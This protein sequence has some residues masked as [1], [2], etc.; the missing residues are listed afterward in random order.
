MSSNKS[1]LVSEDGEVDENIFNLKDNQPM[2]KKAVVSR[3][4]PK[5]IC[6]NKESKNKQRETYRKRSI[7]SLRKQKLAT[8]KWEKK[9]SNTYSIKSLWQCNGD[10]G[11]NFQS[12]TLS[13]LGK[14]L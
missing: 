4:K 12:Y 10:L 14:S 5:K 2:I 13:R 11:F 6:W 3:G 7:L 9:V 1:K 8:Q